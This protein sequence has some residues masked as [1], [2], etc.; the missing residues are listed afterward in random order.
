MKYSVSYNYNDNLKALWVEQLAAAAILREAI[1]T[2][3]LAT[4]QFE[5][6]VKRNK[7]ATA[8]WKEAW[9]EFFVQNDSELVQMKAQINQLNKEIGIRWKAINESLD[10]ALKT[11]E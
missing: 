2:Q 1:K 8:N 6:A 5:A 4:I 11:G 10:A 7:I 9:W 3:S